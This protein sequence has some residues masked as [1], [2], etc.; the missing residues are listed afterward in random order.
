MKQ[1]DPLVEEEEDEEDEMNGLSDEKV[2]RE[3]GVFIKHE[4][5]TDNGG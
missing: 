3:I 1:I 5:F 4:D 2:P